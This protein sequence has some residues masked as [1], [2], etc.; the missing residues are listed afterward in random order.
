MK[1]IYLR[2]KDKHWWNYLFMYF[3]LLLYFLISLFDFNYIII[4]IIYFIKILITQI[5][6]ILFI[7]FLF[8]F[9]FNLLIQNEKIIKKI[10]NSNSFTKYIFIILFWII[11]TWPVYMWY[12]IIEKLQ[13]HGLWYEHVATFIYSRA[14]KIPFFAIMIFYFWIKYTL[15]FNFTILIFAILIWVI[16]NLFSNFIKYEDN[17]S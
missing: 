12:P 9:I 5:I 14:I 1:N 6:P 10:S 13:K 3:V 8:I 2:M 7:V 4:S 15:L 17:N 16:I 11:S